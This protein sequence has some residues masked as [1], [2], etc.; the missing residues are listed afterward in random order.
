MS[1][2]VIAAKAVSKSFQSAERT[3]DILCGADLEVNEGESVAV[4]GASGS[5]KSTLL[6]ILAGLDGAC[7]GRV[8][9][10]GRNLATLDDRQRSSLR[11]ANTAFVFQSYHLLP[12]LSA[13][14]NVALPLELF[15]RDLPADRASA[16][17]SRLGLADRASHFPHQ[18][19]GGEQQRVALARAF[20]LEPR[21]LFADEPTANLDRET[22][23]EIIDCMFTM[24]ESTEAALVLVTHDPAVATRCQRVLTLTQGVLR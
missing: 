13:L 21:V 7:S 22:A 9:L 11:A 24:H 19:S 17:L 15:G 2:A 1:Q 4:V 12:D 14:E 8:D 20:A 23:G 16:W 5:G 10:C 3:I 18:L 6:G